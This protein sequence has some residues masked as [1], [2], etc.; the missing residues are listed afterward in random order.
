M[1]LT[2]RLA[3]VVSRRRLVRRRHGASAVRRRRA[4]SRHSRRRGARRRR[5]HPGARTMRLRGYG[6]DPY[7]DGGSLIT[8]EPTA[9]EK[10]TI[11]T[12][13]E[14]VIDLANGRTRVRAKQSRAFVF[15]AEAMMDG[16]PDRPA[17]STATSRST[18]RPAAPR[19]VC[20]RKSRRN[21]AWSCSRI[22]SSP[23][24]R[25]SI[26]AAASRTGA[27]KA[28]RRSSTSRRRRATRSRSP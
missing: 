23:C 8:T 26:R 28:R 7:Q 25:R 16:P 20:R 11:I 2:K 5:A 4:P 27:R 13:Y 21:G 9:P 15:A 10:M 3:A 12:A 18:S 6:H 24:A 19:G 17:R 22:R 14:R 1:Q